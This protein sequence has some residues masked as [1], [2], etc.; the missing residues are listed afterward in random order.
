MGR[1][2]ARKQGR[3]DLEGEVGEYEAYWLGSYFRGTGWAKFKEYRFEWRKHMRNLDEGKPGIS[4]FQSSGFGSLSETKILYPLNDSILKEVFQKLLN[5]KKHLYSCEM[6]EMFTE[7]EIDV[8]K[9]A[10]SFSDMGNYSFLEDDNNFLLIGNDFILRFWF[11][12][13]TTYSTLTYS[14]Y[15]DHEKA[16]YLKEEAKKRSVPYLLKATTAK[17]VSIDWVCQKKTENFTEFINETIH[18]EAYPAIKNLEK[19]IGDFIKSPAAILLLCGT[20]GMGKTRLIRHILTKFEDPDIVYTSDQAVFNAEEF[21]VNFRLGNYNL[22]VIEDADVL[23]KTRK[24]GNEVM[25]R[26]LTAS[27]GIFSGN[28]KKMVI[29]TNLNLPDVDEALLRPGRCFAAVDLG[30][31]TYDQAV[32]LANKL[33]IKHELPRKSY[34]V[35]DVYA[36]SRIAE[37]AEVIKLSNKLGFGKKG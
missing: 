3:P 25:S 37:K 11:G 20:P 32:A 22:M 33:G 7:K 9:L 16:E 26:L 15:C 18:P 31:M 19:L 13:H 36:E 5:E 29:T 8:K 34:T 6:D 23:L 35:A 27:D 30:V 1:K 21:Y 4:I 28:G 10:Q 17:K 14:I 24:E 2:Q 12:K